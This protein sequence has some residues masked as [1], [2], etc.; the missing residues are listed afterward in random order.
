MNN[1]ETFLKWKRRGATL[2]EIAKAMGI[3]KQ[4]ALTILSKTLK[5]EEW[6]TTHRH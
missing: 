5:N 1:E 6:N 4:E 2:D 3:T